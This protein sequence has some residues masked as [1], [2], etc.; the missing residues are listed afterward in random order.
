M[1][2]V[3]PEL[4]IKDRLGTTEHF[5]GASA[6]TAPFQV[7]PVAGAVITHFRIFVPFQSPITKTLKIS[8]DGGVNFE[9][10]EVGDFL[11]DEMHGNVT[12]VHL[13]ANQAGV[14]YEIVL[15]RDS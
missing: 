12:Q 13:L 9:T 3:A 1:P 7:P 5:N 15:N 2:D 14:D 8:F 11:S 10:L 6:G 4:E